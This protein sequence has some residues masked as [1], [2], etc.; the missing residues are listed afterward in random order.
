[1]FLNF[2]PFLARVLVR[3]NHK[4]LRCL[5]NSS[6]NEIGSRPMKH[7]EI[8]ADNLHK[9][10]WSLGWVSTL[11][12]EGRTIWIVDAHDYGKRFI[13]RA[14]EMLTTFVEL[15]AG[16]FAPASGWLQRMVRFWARI[17]RNDVDIM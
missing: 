3:L 1:M 9:A 10:G 16:R 17:V 4:G 14:D 8:I 2:L 6:R 12:L 15:E 13:V 11:D 7:S 5:E